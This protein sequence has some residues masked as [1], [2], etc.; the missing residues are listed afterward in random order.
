MLVP[1]ALTRPGDET[2]PAEVVSGPKR[3]LV[4]VLAATIVAAFGLAAA[5]EAWLPAHS[6]R[7]RVGRASPCSPP[8]PPP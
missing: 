7:W 1:D 8:P 2:S 4:L 6:A 5:V 3:P